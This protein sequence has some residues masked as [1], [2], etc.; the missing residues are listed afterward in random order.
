[1]NESFA[2]RHFKG[3]SPIG[4]RLQF[5]NRSSKGY[6]YTIVGVVTEIRDR[7][8]TQDLRPT[9]YRVHE[10]ADQSG[11]QPSG[12]VV[13][14]AVDPASIV[15]S[16]R[17]AIWSLDRNQP[18]ARVQTVE[19]IV[20]RQLSVPSQNTVLLGAF[21]FL[22][23][24]LASIGLYGVLSYAVTQRT[25]EIGLRMA[26]GARS[27]DIL[28]TFT[29]RGLRFTVAGLAIGGAMALVAARAMR[30]LFYD[31]QPDYVWAIA[32]ASV[33]LLAVAGVASLV[34]A[35]RASR[36]NPMSALQRE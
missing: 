20:T 22:A 13:R 19:D 27:R 23:L 33:A 4:E 24:L 36:I 15:P 26:L 8:V 18:I 30:T 31:F 35:R 5:G 32:M 6:W 16:L 14:T 11:D 29:G 1:V 10:Q 3:R 2:N 12:I 7:G 17:Q 34:P 21:A 25:N 9:V 28:I